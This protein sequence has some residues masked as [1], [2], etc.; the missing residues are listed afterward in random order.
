MNWNEEDHRRDTRG[1]FTDSAV[2]SWLK[3]AVRHLNDRGLKRGDARPPGFDAAIAR[4]EELWNVPDRRK[5]IQRTDEQQEELDTLERAFETYR[6]GLGANERDPFS[7]RLQYMDSV[8]RRFDAYGRIVGTPFLLDGAGR[9]NRRRTVDRMGEIK[10]RRSEDWSGVPEGREQ[11][12]TED[13]GKIGRRMEGASEAFVKEMRRAQARARVEGS[14]R[15]AVRRTP[16]GTRVE[17][18]MVEADK[19]IGATRGA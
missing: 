18:W 8:G 12:A 15:E 16:R 5:G 17:G 6:K 7:N 13:G 4:S 1:R 19:R 14:A 3:E 11:R 2:N 10:G 9:Q